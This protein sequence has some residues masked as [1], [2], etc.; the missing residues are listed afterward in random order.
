MCQ[1]G[2]ELHNNTSALLSLSAL[3]RRPYVLDLCMAP[4]GFTASVLKRNRNVRVCGISL[5]PS[6]GGHK[7]LIPN[8]ETDSRIQVCFLDITMLAAEMGVT[9]IPPKH[10]DANNFSLDHPFHGEKFD[11]VFCDGQVL[12]MHSR[13]EYREKREAWRLTITQL[14]LALQ[15]IK[16][17]GKIVVLLHRVDAWDTIALLHA[18]SKFS[19]LRFFKP[20]KKHAIR[21]SFYVVAEQVQPQSIDAL[22]AV[23]TWKKNWYIATFGSD[24]EYLENRNESNRDVDDVLSDFGPELI[25]LGR[26]IWRI[27][28]DALRRASFITQYS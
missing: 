15:K 23:A 24:A 10:P 20:V 17:D 27:Q 12:R 19:S 26:P 6:Q 2:E 5:P 28:N 3:G 7:I 21:S 8:W 9:T 16:V 18:L 22:Q 11:L 13:A 1:I 4:G 25:R 14:V